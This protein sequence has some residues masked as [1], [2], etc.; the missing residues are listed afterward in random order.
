MHKC[1]APLGEIP[2]VCA[3]SAEWSREYGES[4]PPP[5]TDKK[6]SGNILIRTSPSLHARLAVE[7]ADQNVSMNHWMVQKLAD[8][9]PSSLLDW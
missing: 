3:R 7:A 8:R 1:P 5:I 2:N 4:V 9:P 6:F